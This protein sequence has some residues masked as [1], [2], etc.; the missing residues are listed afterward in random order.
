[1]NKSILAITLFGCLLF[2]VA[3]TSVPSSTN[4]V[5][6]AWID[7]HNSG[8]SE[9][10]TEFIQLHYHSDLLS[11]AQIS[12]H[13]NFYRTLKNNFGKVNTSIYKV[14]EDSENRLVVHLLKEGIPIVKQ[15][16]K[17]ENVLIVQI[18]MQGT[19]LK[20]GLGLGSLLCQMKE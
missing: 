9:N 8:S 16:V 3:A 1:M 5:L 14:I 2:S 13:I 6:K 11:H 18:D 17:P 19:K 10:F 15:N 4:T 12:D 7:A 20:R